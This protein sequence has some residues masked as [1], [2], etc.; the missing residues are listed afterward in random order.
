M[1]ENQ[2]LK[3]FLIQDRIA[4]FIRDH[5]QNKAKEPDKKVAFREY[6]QREVPEKAPQIID[7]FIKYMD[8]IGVDT[9]ERMEGAYK[10][11]VKD[12]IRLMKE[13]SQV[14]EDWR[15]SEG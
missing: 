10:M 1:E 7:E 12:G 4:L 6:L 9:G 8:W 3:E 13:I 14:K 5:N 2:N 11:G 15:M